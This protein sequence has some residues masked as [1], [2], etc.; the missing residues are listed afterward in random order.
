[1]CFF[2]LCIIYFYTHIMM[3]S[4]TEFPLDWKYGTCLV[5]HTLCNLFILLLLFSLSLY[6]TRFLFLSW[7]V[8]CSFLFFYSKIVSHFCSPENLSMSLVNI[9]HY[10]MRGF[11]N[12]NWAIYFR[13]N[14][15]DFFGCWKTN[16]QYIYEQM[17]F[18]WQPYDA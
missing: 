4:H 7:V 9:V 10:R 5:S 1:M 15:F 3:R 11:E 8:Y 16:L 12:E 18:L 14:E 6:L 17:L 13:R 2:V